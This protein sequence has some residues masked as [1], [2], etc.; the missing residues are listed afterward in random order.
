MYI[1]DTFDGSGY[2]NLALEVFANAV[3]A[4][5][6]IENPN[7]SVS[8]VSPTFVISDNGHGLPFDEQKN[9]ELFRD[10]ERSWAEVFLEKFHSTPTADDHSPHFHIGNR[11]RG[12]GLV[13]V[14]ALSEYLRIET[15]RNG[16]LWACEY[17]RGTVVTP[18]KIIGE[19]DGVGTTLS[20]RPDSQI[21][22]G[23]N[24]SDVAL[25]EKVVETSFLI[26]KVQYDFLNETYYSEN[27][28]FDLLGCTEPN[29][30]FDQEVS[31]FRV[32]IGMGG[33]SNEP[34]WK[35]WV[36]GIP[37]IDGGSHHEAV[38]R[39]LNLFNWMP[40][41]IYIHLIGLEYEYAGP[42]RDRVRAPHI[43]EPL[44]EAISSQLTELNF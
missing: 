2:L 3:D 12:V 20:F 40:E 33:R 35:S 26:P 8:S 16:K 22:T 44:S 43:I 15:W 34:T 41:Q 13:V 7:V 38:Q 23:E 21:F 9:L 36:N 32:L 1:G 11:L 37:S 28:L 4:V 6:G 25:Q 14:N 10:F 42:T 18:P 31:G 19:G 30:K 24:C 17:T 5:Y 39:A 29:F 27:G